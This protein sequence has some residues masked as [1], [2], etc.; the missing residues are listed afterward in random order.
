[1]PLGFGK[2]TRRRCG[3]IMFVFC[4]LIF[5]TSG[6]GVS[7]PAAQAPSDTVHHQVDLSWEAPATSPVEI[8][9]YHVYR[10]PAGGSAYQLL[11]TSPA[12]ETV[13]LDTTVQSGL[14]YNYFVT[15]VDGSGVESGASNTVSVSIP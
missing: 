3:G 14:S 7:T 10:A 15:S 4:S 8:I 9:G 5:L 1:M 11:N 6:C 13:Y 2:R 12:V